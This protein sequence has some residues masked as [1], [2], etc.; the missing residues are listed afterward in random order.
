M[1]TLPRVGGRRRE[2]VRSAIMSRMSEMPSSPL[3]GNASC[4]TIFM[5]LYCF[6]IVRGRHLHAAVVAVA[7]DG[8]VEHVGRR[9]S[10]SRRRRRPAMSRRR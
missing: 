1:V 3:S 4:R 2:S 6:G 5:P 8:E 7:R 10:R 9:S